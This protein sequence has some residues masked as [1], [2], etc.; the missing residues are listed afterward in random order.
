M[1]QNTVR[2][3]IHYWKE[4]HPQDTR[5]AITPRIPVALAF[6]ADRNNADAVIDAII[7]VQ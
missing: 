1:E 3:S 2:A 7:R 5:D 4:W 6:E